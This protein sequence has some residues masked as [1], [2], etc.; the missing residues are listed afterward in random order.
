MVSDS[1]WESFFWH[2]IS[3]AQI[4][5]TRVKKTVHLSI[6]WSPERQSDSR[7]TSYGVWCWWTP[8]GEGKCHF[9]AI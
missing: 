2:R 4:P 1:Q 9:S 3:D 5:L 6:F 7:T 8:Q